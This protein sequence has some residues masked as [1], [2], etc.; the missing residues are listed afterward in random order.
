MNKFLF[1]LTFTSGLLFNFY[2][3]VVGLQQ[4]PSG[5]NWD[6][7]SIGYNAY[8]LMLTGKDEYGYKMPLFL[9]SFNDYK[10][11]L[12]SYLSIPFIY[13]F[14]LNQVSVRLVSVLAGTLALIPLYFFLRIFIKN[15]YLAF[16]LLML[17]ALGPLR[18]HF[19]RLALE[20]NLSMCF[21]S[22]GAWWFYKEKRLRSLVMFLLSAYA[23]HA[24][25]IVVPIFLLLNLLEKKNTKKIFVNFIVFAILSIPLF[26]GKGSLARSSAESILK[27]SPFTPR[28][29]FSNWISESY[30]FLGLLSGHMATL[31]SPFD[32][33]INNWTWTKG[34][35]MSISEYSIIGSLNGLMLVGGFLIFIKNLSDKNYRFVGYWLI[36][37]FL[38][39]VLSA[40]WFHGIRAINILIPLEIISV[41]LWNKIIKNILVSGFLIIL[42]CFQTMFVFSNELVF[43]NYEN[44]GDFFADSFKTG[45]KTVLENQDKYKLVIINNEK[46]QT[47][48]FWL[49]YLKVDPK[50]V[51]EAV[52][53]NKGF[54]KYEIRKTNWSEDQKLKNILLWMPNT[55]SKHDIESVAGAK[56][57]GYALGLTK[58]RVGE[59]IVG[60]E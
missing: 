34:F 39:S 58:D 26:F 2:I 16:G 60:L 25:K 41:L 20:A 24:G 28:E 49:F 31:L 51:Q 8:S 35:S 36:A 4:S 48:I 6:E 55:I 45:A 40:D 19:S 29:I 3:R 11:A 47:Y 33:S 46:P 14:G 57:V 42:F 10:P 7:A 9:R 17:N 15:K 27:F 23:Y 56:V 5:V 37:A 12:Y 52:D 43:T 30:Y 21:F 38:P 59:V 53:R 50:V 18:I 54:G 22:W 13:I 1:V 32:L 44:M